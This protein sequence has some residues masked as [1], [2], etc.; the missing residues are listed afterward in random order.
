MEK[1]TSYKCSG[2]VVLHPLLIGFSTVVLTEATYLTLMMSGVYF[3]LRCLELESLRACGIAGLFFGLAYLTR[4]EA[5]ALIVLTIVWMYRAWIYRTQRDSKDSQ[6]SGVLI[7]TFLVSQSRTYG[8]F[9]RIAAHYC[10][11]RKVS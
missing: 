8:F 3:G 6:I 7:A 2:L 10:L 1:R 9:Q 4:P 5:F 11:R